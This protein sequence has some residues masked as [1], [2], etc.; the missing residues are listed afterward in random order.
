MTSVLRR[1]SLANANGFG[2]VIVKISSSLRKFLAHARLRQNSLAIANATA[3]CTQKGG[4][5]TQ[6]RG[7]T[8]HKTPPQRQFW[9]P[10]PPTYDKFSPSVCSR[11]VMLLGG[12]G[13]RPDQSDFLGPPKLVLEGALYSTF[14]P[15]TFALYIP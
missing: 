4:W 5:K 10:P 7:K 2:N 6:G 15:P 8:Y 14:S 3:W 12:N 9:K 11:P 13:H 1:N